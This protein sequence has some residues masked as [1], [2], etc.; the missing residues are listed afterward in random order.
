MPQPIIV[1]VPRNTFN[2]FWNAAMPCQR[3]IGAWDTGGP[4]LHIAQTTEKGD[5][6]VIIKGDSFAAEIVDPAKVPAEVGDA[7]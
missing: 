5:S 6:I 2:A 4:E 1:T 7:G 3:R